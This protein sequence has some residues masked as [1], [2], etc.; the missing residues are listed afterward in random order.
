MEIC[1]GANFTFYGVLGANENATY[2][3]TVWA[4]N[5]SKGNIYSIYY[6]CSDTDW[7]MYTEIAQA[8]MYSFM[9]AQQ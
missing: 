9:V 2:G 6:E 3:T 5:D 4:C 7:A 1:R 8:I